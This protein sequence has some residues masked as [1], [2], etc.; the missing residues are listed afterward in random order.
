VEHGL[1]DGLR[2]KRF[3]VDFSNEVDI[4]EKLVLSFEFSVK[5]VF[6]LFPLFLLLSKWRLK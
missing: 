2:E 3:F 5:T 4:P 6:F 1:K